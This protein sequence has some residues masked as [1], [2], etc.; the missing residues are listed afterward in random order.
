MFCAQIEKKPTGP[1]AT[2]LPKP[3]TM[4][5]TNTGTRISGSIQ[6]RPGRSVRIIRKASMPPSGMAMMA[7]PNARMKPLFSAL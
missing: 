4:G 1:A 7:S 3:S 5:D 6:R 2:T